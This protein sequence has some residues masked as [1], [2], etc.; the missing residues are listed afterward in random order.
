MN[1]QKEKKNPQLCMNPSQNPQFRFA[2]FSA[3]ETQELELG[4]H[5]MPPGRCLSLRGPPEHAQLRRGQGSRAAVP[6]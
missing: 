3:I 6:S 5:L 2:Q 4:T 1:H